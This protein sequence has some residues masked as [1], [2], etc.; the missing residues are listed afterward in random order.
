LRI[1]RITLS[2]RAFFYP[3][4]FSADC[5]NF[6]A[7]LAETFLASS[8]FGA[9]ELQM[10]VLGACNALGYMLP[11]VATGLI[12]ERLGRR[13]MCALSAAGL[14]AVNLTEPHLRSV[15]AL[16]VAGFLRMFATSFLWP[17]L[18]AWLTQS[19]RHRN[20][21]GVLGGFN[22]S[23][24]SGIMTGFFIGG[25]AFQHISPT[26]AF[27]FSASM[28]LLLLIFV[29]TC[30][31]RIHDVEDG[32]Q[33]DAL[34]PLPQIKRHEPDHAHLYIRQGLLLNTG[35]CFVTSMVLYL[36]PKI[37]AGQLTE[38]AQG[39]MHSVRMGGQVLAFLLFGRT[40]VWHYRGWPVWLTLGALATGLVFISS[41]HSNWFYLVGCAALGFGAGAA[42][43][44]SIFYSLALTRIKGLGSG[45]QESLIGAGLLLG[46]LYG[47]LI[48]SMTDVRLTV[49]AALIPLALLLPW[50]KAR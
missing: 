45:I 38:A 31:P 23:W 44:L 33:S 29:L 48:A 17:P 5:F 40:A 20:L 21:S 14:I 30:T 13:V 41:A 26:A 16:Y 18:I 39:T 1:Y 4:G 42:Y 7:I 35:A 22:F 50:L 3:I 43:S 32:G 10:G 12:S 11:C 34:Q 37:A 25:W 8:L 28:A 15:P 9:T 27:Y 6:T 19:T 47:G 2:N 36:F 24:A 46:P 49:I